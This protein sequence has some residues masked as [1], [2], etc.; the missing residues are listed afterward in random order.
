VNAGTDIVEVRHVASGVVR[1]GRVD[2]HR[3]LGLVA[4]RHRRRC[5]VAV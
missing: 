2:P 4:R 1:V 3:L 5:T